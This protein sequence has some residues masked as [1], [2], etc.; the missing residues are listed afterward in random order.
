M[1]SSSSSSSSSS[2]YPP[3]PLNSQLS[4]GGTEDDKT[5]VVLS[6]CGVTRL[7]VEEG[8]R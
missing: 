1:P 8:A 7:G 3:S 4:T 5:G 6:A 2:A